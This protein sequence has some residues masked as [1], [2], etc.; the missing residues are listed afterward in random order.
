MHPARDEPGAPQ[1][2]AIPRR[3][4]PGGER[5]VARDIV[6]RR[7]QLEIRDAAEQRGHLAESALQLG[8]GE[9]VEKAGGDDQIERA[10]Q[11]ERIERID[12]PQSDMTPR[13]EPGDDVGAGVDTRVPDRR[14]MTADERIPVPLAAP[15]V[16]HRPDRAAQDLLGDGDAQRYFTL[17]IRR[18]LHLVTGIAIPSVKIRTVIHG[19]A[20]IRARRAARNSAI[21]ALACWATAACGLM[22]RAKRAVTPQPDPPELARWNARIEPP[23]DTGF[24]TLSVMHGYAWMAP[25]TSDVYRIRVR[26]VLIHAAPEVKYHWEIHRGMCDSDRGMFGPPVVYKP[27]Q[28]DSTGYGA[29]SVFIPLGFPTRGQYSVWV[30][31]LDSASAPQP[32][33][34]TFTPPG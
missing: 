27:L 5:G 29:T 18:G 32:V 2:A 33:C 4:P 34:G 20:M 3:R 21:I 12:R 19:P 10:T 6:R 7:E 23:N 15:D 30:T 28:A 25:V 24:D 11:P 26:V 1:C 16:E 22:R 17:S 8:V 31:P 9:I 14:P 13:A